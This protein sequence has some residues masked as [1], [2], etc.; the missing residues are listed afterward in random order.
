MNPRRR[1][2]ESLILYSHQEIG[3]KKAVTRQKHLS[4]CGRCQGYLNDLQQVSRIIE[5]HHEFPSDLFLDIEQI[6]RSG[7]KPNSN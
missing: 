6:Q 1:Y 7:I 4:Q 5:R 3:R 2:E